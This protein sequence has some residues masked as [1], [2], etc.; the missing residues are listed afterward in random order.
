MKTIS[1]QNARS[2]D[3]RGMLMTEMVIAMAILV[4]A[5]LPIGYSLINDGRI[6]R[7]NYRHAVAMEIVD[8]E[9]EILAAGAWQ[10][11]PEGTHPYT[12]RAAAAENLPPGKFQSTRTGNHLRLEWKPDHPHGEGFVIRE[13][14]VK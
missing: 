11:V 7:A 13:V 3:C 2:G 4:I 6:L 1:P 8:G 12:I 14:T 5:V 9:M 10:S